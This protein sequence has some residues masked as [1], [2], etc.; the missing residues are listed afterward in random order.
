MRIAKMANS[1]VVGPGRRF[2]VW[3]AGCPGPYGTRAQAEVAA[4]G[5]RNGHCV[6]CQ[7]AALW[8]SHPYQERTPR[9]IADAIL[10]TGLDVSFVG[11]DP[12]AQPEQLAAVLRNLR[13]ARPS[14]HIIVYT[15][16]YWEVLHRHPDYAMIWP[17]IDVL[18]DGPYRPGLDDNTIQWR[19]SRNQRAIDV[20]ASLRGSSY[21]PVV[22]NW[23]TPTFTI[24]PDGDVVTA[25]GLTALLDGLGA[26]ERE[27][28]CGEV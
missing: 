28:R 23:D 21:A 5:S 19:G 16:G 26:E 13:H 1:D 15:G 4:D 22:L 24:T 8:R 6:G 14:I 12:L 18:V 11:G 10:A 25:A 2:A 7:A 20:P 9:E 27:V 17:L 3:T